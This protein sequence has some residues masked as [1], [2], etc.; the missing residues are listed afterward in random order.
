MFLLSF[1]SH[2]VN[3]PVVA[4]YDGE[5]S[6]EKRGALLWQLPV[7]DC[8]NRSGAMEFSCGGNADDFFP[9]HVSFYSKKAYSEI[10]VSVSKQSASAPARGSVPTTLTSTFSSVGPRL[11]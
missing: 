9:V 11:L 10:K 3:A 5:Y 6:Y 1:C 7:I 4:E 2:G 8:N